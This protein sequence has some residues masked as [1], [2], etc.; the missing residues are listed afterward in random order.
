M[1]NRPT[2]ARPDLI[3]PGEIEQAAAAVAVG[4]L[5]HMEFRPPDGVTFMAANC[6][7]DAGSLVVPVEAERAGESELDDGEVRIHVDTDGYSDI[8]VDAFA[9]LDPVDLMPGAKAGARGRLLPRYLIG[10]S[11]VFV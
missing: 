5:Q 9:H 1:H 7:H 8:L 11:G 3:Q 4:N 6:R 2:A 10:N